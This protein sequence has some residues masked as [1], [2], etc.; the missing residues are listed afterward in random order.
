MGMGR[1]EKPEAAGGAQRMLGA[2][3]YHFL[4][5]KSQRESGYVA[6]LGGDGSLEKTAL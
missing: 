5:E 6:G 1:R 2:G 4:I 3:S